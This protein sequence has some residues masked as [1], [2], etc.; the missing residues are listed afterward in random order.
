MSEIVI[1]KPTR[2]NIGC[3]SFEMPAPRTGPPLTRYQKQLTAVYAYAFGY[4]GIVMSSIGPRGLTGIL[5]CRWQC[6]V[7]VVASR[8]SRS[9]YANGNIHAQRTSRD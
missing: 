1:G 9:V 3:C 6:N 7:T 8:L 4:L 5:G 2:H